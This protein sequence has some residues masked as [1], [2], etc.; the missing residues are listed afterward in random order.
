M[1][2]VTPYGSDNNNR[3][4]FTTPVNIMGTSATT[5]QVDE[6]NINVSGTLGTG[7][8][9]ATRVNAGA[10]GDT[11]S[12]VSSTFN[13]SATPAVYEAIVRGG[14]L[15]HDVTNYTSYL[16]VG[17]NFS[18]GRTGN[19]YF[20]ILLTRGAV[21]EFKINVTGTYAGCFVCL[22]EN[23]TWTT[24]LSNTNGWADMSN[25]YSGAGNPNNADNGCALGTVMSGSSGTFTCVFGTESSSNGNNK[26]LVRFKLTSGQSISNIKF[27]A[28]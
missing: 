13:A 7:S 16:P 17:P 2:V 22:P 6:D 5:S 19:Q 27:Q 20:Q 15:R 18:S 21:S 23:S 26:I 3:V 1:D 11:P 8:G 25:A 14:T 10:T 12:P 28:T 4:S 9:N 24:G